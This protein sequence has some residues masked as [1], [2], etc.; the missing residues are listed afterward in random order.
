MI[1]GHLSIYLRARTI[2]TY[3]T[4]SNKSA[5][6]YPT[7]QNTWSCFPVNKL[8]QATTMGTIPFARGVPFPY[9]ITLPARLYLLSVKL[10]HPSYAGSILSTDESHLYDGFERFVL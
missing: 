2:T 10:H 9:A 4:I 5:N 3:C 6:T 1:D 8:A 7:G